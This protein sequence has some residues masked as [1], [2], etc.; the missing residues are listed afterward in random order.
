[1]ISALHCGSA[2]AQVKPR[3]LRQSVAREAVLLKNGEGAD[4]NI[5]IV[6]GSERRKA[7]ERSQSERTR[8]AECGHERPSMKALST[9]HPIRKRKSTGAT[10]PLRSQR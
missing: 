10:P 3:G 2:G 4:R 9:F 7:E 6:S 8:I 1:M 5:D